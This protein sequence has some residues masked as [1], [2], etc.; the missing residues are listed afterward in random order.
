MGP[1][2]RESR[3]LAP[4]GR[5]G[6]SSRNLGMNNLGTTLGTAVQSLHD[7]TKVTHDMTR[8]T[9]QIAEERG[10]NHDGRSCP[11]RPRA[12]TLHHGSPSVVKTLI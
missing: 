9:Y 10:Q 1:R 7:S 12:R 11:Q 2:L 6:A 8:L 4:S 3:L 5:G